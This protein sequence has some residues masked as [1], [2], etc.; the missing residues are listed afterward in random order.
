LACKY[1]KV[2][3]YQAKQTTLDSCDLF[4]GSHKESYKD[5][6]K[7]CLV[8][9]QPV[10]ENQALMMLAAVVA[11]VGLSTQRHLLQVEQIQHA[12]M[13]ACCPETSVPPATLF[14]QGCQLQGAQEHSV[15]H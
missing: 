13:N 8:W 10:A 4:P 11:M 3:P 9:R 14:V 12:R 7:L 2:G 15:E 5:T 6:N 1:K